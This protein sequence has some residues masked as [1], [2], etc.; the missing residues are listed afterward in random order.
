MPISEP[1]LHLVAAI[2][3]AVN[4]PLAVAQGA[5][6]PT[7]IKALDL[8]KPFSA[9]SAWRLT[10]T[11]DADVADP[12]GF[13]DD[14]VPGPVHPCLRKAPNAPCDPSLKAT[15][16]EPGKSDFFIEPHDLAEARIVHGPTGQPFLLVQT[17]SVHSGNGDQLV[18]TQ[19]LAYRTSEDRFERVYEHMT[20]HNNNQQ[21]RYIEAGPLK[22]D[23]VSVEPTQDA[24]F[25][26]WVVVNAPANGVFKPVLR[27][28]SATRYGDGN[29]LAVIDSEMPN[30]AQ[31]LGLWK[32]GSRLP[33]PA[34]A[35][36]SPHLVRMA[37]WCVPG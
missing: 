33:L 8:S 4:A 13:L 15:V 16:G 6:P 22:G 31:R 12:T 21:V 30:M 17:G 5:P 36:P 7:V 18:R 3:L 10:V 34:G 27:Y 2:A 29:P 9:R 26:F 32:P 14:K 37:L 11:R 25:G 28:R 24:P 19:L 20:G 1:T 35:C 23:I